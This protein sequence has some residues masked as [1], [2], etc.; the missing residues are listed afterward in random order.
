M[1]FTA[2]H[3]GGWGAEYDLKRAL[4][5]LCHGWLCLCWP[6]QGKA[7]V[8]DRVF[9]TNSTQEQVYST[10]AKQIVKGESHTWFCGVFFVSM[11]YEWHNSW[12]KNRQSTLNYH[13]RDI[14]VGGVTSHRQFTGAS[15]STSLTRSKKKLF[16]WHDVVT[17]PACRSITMHWLMTCM[18]IMAQQDRHIQGAYRSNKTITFNFWIFFSFPSFCLHL[19][20][21]VRLFFPC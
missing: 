21:S 16:P 17:R 12:G 11:T 9:P 10:C 7:Y 14:H 1:H 15:I 8:F 6:P 18:L 19:F 5:R 3:R 20:M 2:R 13:N 4:N